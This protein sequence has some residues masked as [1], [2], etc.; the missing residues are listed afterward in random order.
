MRLQ[1][2][3]I[4]TPKLT[5]FV[6]IKTRSMWPF[7]QS[8]DD[9]LHHPLNAAISG[10][11]D[12]LQC[13]ASPWKRGLHGHEVGISRQETG[14]ESSKGL[15]P[16]PDIVQHIDPEREVKMFSRLG[17]QNLK[18]QGKLT[19]LPSTQSRKYVH[20]Y[21]L[22]PRVAQLVKGCS[23][24]RQTRA[25]PRTAYYTPRNPCFPSTLMLP[26]KVFHLRN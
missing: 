10:R 8:A 17:V 22:C 7:H 6:K 4:I 3:R 16:M 23:K 11:T 9:L 15:S 12:A 20:K 1:S 25:G 13:T 2:K 14:E 18:N 21:P 5:A 24:H 19:L 26:A